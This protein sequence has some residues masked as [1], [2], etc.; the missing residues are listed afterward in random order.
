MK[1]RARAGSTNHVLTYIWKPGDTRQR[2][3]PP[4]VIPSTRNLETTVTRVFGTQRV[5]TTKS[6]GGRIFSHKKPKTIALLLGLLALTA[7]VGGGV[8]LATTLSAQPEPSPAPTAVTLPSELSAHFTALNA[9]VGAGVAGIDSADSETKSQLERATG[10][11]SAQ[12]G[13]SVGLAR[14]VTYQSHHVWL[15]PGSAGLCL[16]DFETGSG[17]CGPIKDAIAGT[18]TL[19]VGGNENGIKGGGTIYGIAPNGNSQVVV[20]DANG[21]TEDVPV[22][23]NVYIITHP[24]AVSVELTDGASKVQTVTLPG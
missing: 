12:F 23:H 13:L 4:Q 20:H 17:V 8:A 10:G 22:E 9:G 14:D 11:I 2:I 3:A 18:I 6:G 24:G 21:S 7:V 16:R 15:V 1:S 5:A 19:D